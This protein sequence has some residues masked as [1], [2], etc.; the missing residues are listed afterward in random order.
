MFLRALRMASWPGACHHD[1]PIMRTPEL[2]ALFAAV[3]LR[4]LALL[5]LL[6]LPCCSSTSESSTTSTAI[7]AAQIGMARNPAVKVA[8]GTSL[9][10]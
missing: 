6:C 2:P 1:G 8:R 4:L 3:S 10:P 5:S 7:K 9:L